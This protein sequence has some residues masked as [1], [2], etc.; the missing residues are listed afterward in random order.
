MA[1]LTLGAGV[2]TK[3]YIATSIQAASNASTFTLSRK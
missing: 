2:T 1:Q 3:F